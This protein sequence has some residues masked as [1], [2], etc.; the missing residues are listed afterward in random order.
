MTVCPSA[1]AKIKI[2]YALGAGGAR[3]FCHIGAIQCLEEHGIKPDVIAGSS[4]GALV[5]GAYANG[6]D[7]DALKMMAMQTSQLKFMDF[8]PFLNK[9]LGILKGERVLK[10]IHKVAP[11]ELDIEALPLRYAAVAVDIIKGELVVF[12]TGPLWQAIRASISIPAAF[13]PF[14]IGD[15][16]LVDGGVLCR[17]PIDEAKKMGAD[18]IIAVDAIGDVHSEEE[19]ADLIGLIDRFYNIID[20]HNNSERKVNKADVYVMPTINLKNTLVF[21]GAEE[22]IAAGY[23]AMKMK[24]DEV[25]AV[26]AAARLHK[27]ELLGSAL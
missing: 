21:K 1:D 16:V 22:A 3:G 27:A 5:G 13:R 20:W 14:R 24:I 12:E 10:I 2:G 25:I 17:V 4:M 15:K 9:N 18:V 7:V 6:Y 26:I 11:E 8:D 19:P 23:E